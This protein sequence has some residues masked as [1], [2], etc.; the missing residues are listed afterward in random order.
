MLPK[1]DLDKNTWIVGYGLYLADINTLVVADLHIGYEEALEEQGIH[2]PPIQ[3]G[4][5]KKLILRMIDETRASNLII[6]GDV[7]HEF[8]DILR[9]EWNETLDLLQHLKEKRVNVHIVRGNH[10]N[11]LISVLKRSNIPFHDPYLIVDKY[12]FVHGH[13]PL[14]IEAYSDNI[15]VIILGHEHPAIVL[16]DEL[17]ARMKIKC[18]LVGKYMEKQMIV[19]PSLSPLMPG[20]EV[21][22]SRKTLSPIL[23]EISLDEFRVYAVDLD[24]GVFDFGSVGI[25][26]VFA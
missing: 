10:D 23:A 15:K 13:K 26:R 20:T 8:G 16:R 25:L 12:I 6:L 17:G 18:F 9:Q 22:I 2:I 19:L 14:P 3:Y 7:K 24:S 1:L 4:E 11:F 5:I 21:N